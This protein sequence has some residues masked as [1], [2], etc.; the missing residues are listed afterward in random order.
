MGH[1]LSLFAQ[2]LDMR[3]AKRTRPSSSAQPS[4]PQWDDDVGEPVPPLVEFS[5]DEG[6]PPSVQRHWDD[7]IVMA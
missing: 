5:G 2:R 1:V 7:V 3:R 4:Q 6:I